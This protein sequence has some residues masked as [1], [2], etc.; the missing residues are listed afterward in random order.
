MSGL[1]FYLFF[2]KRDP[3]FILL[4]CPALDDP[5]HLTRHQVIMVVL[6]IEWSG[7]FDIRRRLQPCNRVTP[8]PPTL[9]PLHLCICDLLTS[10][11]LQA[12][13]AAIVYFYFTKLFKA[14]ISRM[15]K[16]GGNKRTLE[17]ES[18]KMFSLFLRIIAWTVGVLL[19]QALMEN[20]LAQLKSFSTPK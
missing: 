17:E 4:P 16:V 13:L 9:S 12:I 3:L 10:T 19:G 6:Y 14:L 15:E 5:T 11:L 1:H 8:L 7:R 18:S 2:L 20:I